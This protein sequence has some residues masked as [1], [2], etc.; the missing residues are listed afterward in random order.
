[1]FENVHTLPVSSKEVNLSIICRFVRW[2]DREK[3]VRA[4]RQKL[5]GTEFSVITDLPKTLRAKRAELLKECRVIRKEK[6]K[7]ARVAERGMEVVLQYRDKSSE[8]WKKVTK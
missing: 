6:G 7:R 1:M 3:C 5:R 8:Q 4:T 2:S